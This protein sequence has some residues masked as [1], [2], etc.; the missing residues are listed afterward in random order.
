MAGHGRDRDNFKASLSS[1]LTS[2]I[3]NGYI[4]TGFSHAFSEK[5]SAEGGA[6]L[7]IPGFAKGEEE[8]EHDSILSGGEEGIKWGKR[9]PEFRMGVRFWPEKFLEG[10]YISIGCCHSISAW[11]D[12]A[13]GLGYAAGI[14]K[15]LGI[16][17]GYELMLIE[18]LKNGLLNTKG[19]TIRIHY[20]F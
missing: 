18:S 12:M 11:T 9:P 17:T 13:I 10:P 2:L 19:I 4:R 14:W 3:M 1:D 20:R 15:C 8:R 5:W 16:S 7:Q 6:A